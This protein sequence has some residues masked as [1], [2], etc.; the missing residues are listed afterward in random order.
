[1]QTREKYVVGKCARGWKGE[2][3]EAY[4]K[5]YYLAWNCFMKSKLVYVETSTCGG[6]LCFEEL[7]KTY[8]IK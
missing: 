6:I 2:R 1:M 5:L 4:S 8:H 3:H 7:V